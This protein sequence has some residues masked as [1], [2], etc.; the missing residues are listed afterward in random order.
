MLSIKLNNWLFCQE[1]AENQSPSINQL[2]LKSATSMNNC[3]S[4][5]HLPLILIWK[6]NARPLMALNTDHE[7]TLTNRMIVPS[8]SSS[9][10]VA[11]NPG[12]QETL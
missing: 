5:R 8:F 1:S 12:I 11:C 2:F 3:S 10:F 7:Q 4:S 9:R 6:E